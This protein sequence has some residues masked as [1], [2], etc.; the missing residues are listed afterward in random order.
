MEFT[1][2]ARCGRQYGKENTPLFVELVSL[3][4]SRQCGPGVVKPWLASHIRLFD[5]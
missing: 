1:A 2:Q 3:F 5:M 4:F